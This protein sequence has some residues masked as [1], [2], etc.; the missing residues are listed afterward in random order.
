MNVCTLD[1]LV[2][3]FKMVVNSNMGSSVVVLPAEPF[4][5]P[6]VDSFLR[7]YAVVMP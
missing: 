4:L 6:L 2:L 5:Y 1:P 3:E 7:D